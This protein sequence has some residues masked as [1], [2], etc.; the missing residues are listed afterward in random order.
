MNATAVCLQGFLAI[1]MVYG[2][3]GLRRVPVSNAVRPREP[4][5]PVWMWIGARHGANRRCLHLAKEN[6]GRKH[7]VFCAA[8]GRVEP[9][10]RHSGV[11]VCVCFTDV[12]STDLL[13]VSH[14]R[15]RSSSRP[16]LLICL[17]CSTTKYLPDGAA[18]IVR[19]YIEN[20]LDEENADQAEWQLR[21]TGT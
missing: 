8:F 19:V 12:L 16:Y 14:P 7:E 21:L 13:S 1:S 4:A 9:R 20:P 6:D 17:M 5:V 2:Y 15:Q 10:M 11:Y 3:L 18:S